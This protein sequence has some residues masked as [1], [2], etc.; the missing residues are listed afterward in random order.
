MSKAYIEGPEITV[1]ATAAIAQWDRVKLA[2]SSTGQIT[3]SVAGAS[4]KGEAVAMEAI[5]SGYLG[6]VLMMSAANVVPMKAS[7]A[8]TAGAKVYATANGKIDDTGSVV[9]A[10]ALEAATNDGDVI[11]TVPTDA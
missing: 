7:A 9:V 10:R 11:W 2:V 6:R 1:S 3:A 8:I 4:D 5:S